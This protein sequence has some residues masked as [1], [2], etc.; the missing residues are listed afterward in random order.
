T[1]DRYRS[2]IDGILI[3]S[4]FASGGDD[5][6][7]SALHDDFASTGIPVLTIDFAD[8]AQNAP[9]AETRATIA[10]RALAEDFTPYIADDAAFNRL[11]PPT[12]VARAVSV[13]P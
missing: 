1:F 5:T 12:T 4:V 13:S 6:T 7:I 8:A 10:K 11:Y 9:T 2:A 3:E